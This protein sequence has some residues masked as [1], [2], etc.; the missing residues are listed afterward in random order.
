MQNSFQIFRSA[1]MFQEEAW[2]REIVFKIEYYFPLGL[3]S[4]R[5]P[6]SVAARPLSARLIHGAELIIFLDNRLKR[7]L[8]VRRFS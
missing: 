3:L 1:D 5:L 6:I 8:T 7:F 2:G 4:N